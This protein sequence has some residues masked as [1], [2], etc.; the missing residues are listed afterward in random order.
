MTEFS[1]CV[2]KLF[3]FKVPIEGDPSNPL[4]NAFMLRINLFQRVLCYLPREDYSR[5]RAIYGTKNIHVTIAFKLEIHE[6][7]QE[8]DIEYELRADPERDRLRTMIIFQNEHDLMLFVLRW[9]G[10]I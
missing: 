5:P 3:P 1:I 9:K 10:M 6:W 4:G 8:Q 2:D 7:L